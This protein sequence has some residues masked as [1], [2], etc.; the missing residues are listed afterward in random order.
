MESKLGLKSPKSLTAI[1][2]FV[3]VKNKFV[4]KLK[5]KDKFN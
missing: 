4:N 2:L 3:L 5:R 1:K